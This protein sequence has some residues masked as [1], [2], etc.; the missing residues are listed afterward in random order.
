MRKALMLVASA[1]LLAGPLS[2]LPAAAQSG[3]NR[4]NAPPPP[5]PAASQPRAGNQMLDEMNARIAHIKAALKLSP[6]QEK[7]WG[8]LEGAL[9]ELANK[10]L[11]RV[12]AMRERDRADRDRKAPIPL[13][14]EWRFRAD[15]FGE[16]AGKLKMLA[17]AATPLCGTLKDWQKDRFFDL[18]Q[19]I[20]DNW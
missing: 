11:E 20:A 2:L 9:H 18:L 7:M 12:K 17:D 13:V 4:E 1:A 6:D 19:P 10:H 15:M 14:D 3:D 5:P 16:R 8:D